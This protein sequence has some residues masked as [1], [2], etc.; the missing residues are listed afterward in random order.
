MTE[1]KKLSAKAIVADI[2][3]GLANPALMEKYGIS[4]EELKKVFKKLLDAGLI[5]EQDLSS[6]T[7]EE[8]KTIQAYK[9]PSCG[10]PQITKKE[11]CSDCGVIF[12]KFKNKQGQNKID[13]PKTTPETTPVS[14]LRTLVGETLKDDV[15]KAKELNS[16]AKSLVK[17]TL[18][19]DS[20][21]KWI[22]RI[23][24]PIIVVFI[25]VSV[26]WFL[27]YK[28]VLTPEE[29]PNK[30]GDMITFCERE[31]YLSEREENLEKRLKG[32]I[33]AYENGPES[34]G[35]VITSLSLI[36]R[37][38]CGYEQTTIDNEYHDRFP[39]FILTGLS[40][41]RKDHGVKSVYA[42]RVGSVLIDWSSKSASNKAYMDSYGISI[43]AKKKILLETRNL[44]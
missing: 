7:T 2:K 29:I 11:V 24:V 26:Y 23:V 22:V 40:L 10:M 12:E 8:E 20:T 36:Y 32:I 44:K 18:K 37:S 21:L 3:A 39:P 1:K 14:S 9:C 35:N 31:Y 13:E 38:V 28:R 19:K 6:R 42:P 5:T 41:L 25:G 17:Q 15:T 30:V 43:E 27:S 33:D 34:F 4:S 16:K